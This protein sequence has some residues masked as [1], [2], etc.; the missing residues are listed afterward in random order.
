M[1]VISRVTL[2]LREGSSDK[3]YQVVVIQ[4]Q[5]APAPCFNVIASWGRRGGPYAHAVK[6]SR[7]TAAGADRTVAKLLGDKRKKG[8]QDG[9]VAVPLDT[10]IVAAGPAA[11]A[12]GASAPT[13]AAAK[14]KRRLSLGEE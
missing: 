1:S 13:E 3:V 7:V 9:G 12:P 8:Y 11:P 4:V 14:P 10:F 2:G 5:P 6:A